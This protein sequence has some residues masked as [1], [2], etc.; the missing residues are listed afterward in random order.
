M[1]HQRGLPNDGGE[2]CEPW[3]R[4]KQ[5]DGC[6]WPLSLRFPT[7]DLAASLY[8]LEFGYSANVLLLGFTVINFK[9]ESA[10]IVLACEQKAQ[11][12]WV[13]TLTQR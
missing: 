7:P 13:N 1:D 11:W 6:I 12:I 2:D 5:T 9:Q 3:G 10:Q 8:A 4:S